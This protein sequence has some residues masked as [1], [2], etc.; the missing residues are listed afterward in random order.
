MEMQ[1][2]RYNEKAEYSYCFGPFPTFEL[3]ENRPERAVEVLYHSAVT[4]AIREKLER[5]CQT[6]G[7]PCTRADRV[8]ERIR[9]KENCLVAGVFHKYEGELKRE[10]DHIVLVSPSDMGNLGTIIRTSV[11]FGVCD[12]ALIR[13]AAH[14]CHPRTVRA[15]MGSLFRLRFR[16]YDSFEEYAAE[17]AGERELYPFMLEGSK[18]LDEIRRRREA[19]FSLIFGNE[20]TGLPAT[21]ASVGQSVR[22]RHTDSI[23]S[24]NLSL[25]AGI[26][27]YEF[28]KKW[29]EFD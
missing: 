26:G 12:M 19:P 6:Q 14:I 28:T 13:P 15:S 23:D 5:L 16:Y 1:Y 25:A 17:F 8:I 10:T 20:A 21:F 22:I 29:Q 3:L 27:L 4:D 2:K 11:G 24:L 7:I 9:D 18:G